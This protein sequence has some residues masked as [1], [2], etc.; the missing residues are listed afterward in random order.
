MFIAKLS[1]QQAASRSG[2]F[3]KVLIY[4]VFGG[5][6]PAMTLAEPHED[7]SLSEFVVFLSADHERMFNKSDTA[8]DGSDFTPVLDLL[9]SKLVGN[10]R[11][12]GEYLLTDDESELER[13]Q[14]GYDASDESTFWFGRFHTP[15]S[16][17]V[18]KYHHGRFLQSSISRPAIEEWEDDGGVVPVHIG[19]FM[20]DHGIPLDGGSGTRISMA[21][22]AGPYIRNRELVPFDLASPGRGKHRLSAA[23][24][25]AYF[26]DY[27]SESNFGLSGTHTQIVVE[28]NASFGIDQSFDINQTTLGAQ[29]DW[30]MESWQLLAAA[31]YVHSSSEHPAGQFGGWF[32]SGYAELQRELQ[33][34]NT[35]YSRVE[36]N[37][38]AKTADYLRLFPDFST[39][40][41]IVG[42]RYEFRKNQAF[43]V[44]VSDESSVVSSFRQARIQ[45]SAVFP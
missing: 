39:G 37:R 26:P 38:K 4:V 33:E 36:F 18:A 16:A 32:L 5:L 28:E 35:I 43:S 25:I 30:R 34:V 44:E 14:I 45:W 41:F 27:L 13:F 11:F 15:T 29:M 23:I 12:F 21:F 1:R 10:W 2:Q 20:L 24:S 7:G 42:Y 22:G 9:Y 31:Y 17:W 3:L 40:K 6:C 19:G 8:P